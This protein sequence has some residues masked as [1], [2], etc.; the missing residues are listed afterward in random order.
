MPQRPLRASQGP[1]H[2]LVGGDDGR[3]HVPSRPLRPPRREPRRPAVRLRQLPAPRRRRRP[4]ADAEGLRVPRGRHR[5]RGPRARRDRAGAGV[6]RAGARDR[7]WR[8]IVAP[9]RRAPRRSMPVATSRSRRCS[10]GARDQVAAANAPARP[11]TSR[12]SRTGARRPARGPT[13][14]ASTCTTCR[15]SRIGSP[16]SS[17]VPR[18]SS[19][20]RG[21]ARSAGWS[22]TRPRRPDRLVWEDAGSVAFAPYASRSPF[23]VWIVP[24][25]HEADFGRADPA[26]IAAT[27]EALRQVLAG[28]PTASTARPTTSSSTPR[29]CA[30]RSTRPTTG[31]GRST[32]AC[33]RSPASSWEPACRSTP[34]RRRTRSRSC[35]AGAT[36]RRCDGLNG[37]EPGAPPASHRGEVRRPWPCERAPTSSRAASHPPHGAYVAIDRP[38]PTSATAHR[39]TAVRSAGTPMSGK[40]DRDEAAL[41]VETC[42]RS[43]TT[44]SSPTSC[45]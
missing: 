2:R 41:F 24:R 8:T 20:A 11:T 21:S 42:S 36:P 9:P 30:S 17:A 22:G 25:R 31:T 45:G 44:R 39:P 12:S 3:P 10:R 13:T 38:S 7:S 5:R 6:A 29:R 19:S 28:S 27:A 4:G 40:W 43:T 35:S 37:V 16:R 14:C 1:D 32:R 23:E 26:D 18:A 15:R 34:S 33:A